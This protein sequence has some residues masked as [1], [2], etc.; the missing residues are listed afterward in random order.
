MSFPGDYYKLSCG[1]NYY[2]NAWEEEYPLR[3]QDVATA[4]KLAGFVLK[5][6]ARLLPVGFSIKR[7]PVLTNPALKRCSWP[8]YGQFDSYTGV[9]LVVNT[10]IPAVEPDFTT[11]PVCN[12]PDAAFLF[13]LDCISAQY[14]NLHLRGLRDFWL[15]DYTQNLQATATNFTDLDFVG[16]ANSAASASP[17]FN[18]LVAPYNDYAALGIWL[19][20]VRDA[21]AIYTPANGPPATLWN[22]SLY[23]V[24]ATGDPQF[25]FLRTTEVRA[26]ERLAVSAGRQGNFR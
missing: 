14:R 1:I 2:T 23:A 24:G 19:S 4:K 20:T 22:Q 25:Q 5:A 11:T 21:C 13:R 16:I 18:A 10:A 26:G 7:N 3:A 8:L 12:D 17:T 6:R 15:A 9:P